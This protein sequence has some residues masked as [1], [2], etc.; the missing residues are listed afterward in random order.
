MKRL[1][2]ELSLRHSWERFIHQGR[3][4]PTVD[5]LVCKSWQRSR[6]FG[7]N[8]LQRKGSTRLSPAEL[9]QRTELRADFI[10]ISL[11][12]MNHLY[13][14]VQGS[15][16]MV[17]L[18]DE[19]GVLLKVFGD[20]ET[21]RSAEQIQFVE[22]ADWSEEV[23]GT[24]AIGTAIALDTPLQIFAAEH[25]SLACH[26]WTCSASPIHSPTGD[27]IGVLNM[28][29]PFEKVHAH[30]LGMVV[31]AVK[32][33]EN[34]LCVLERNVKNEVM[35]RYLEATV[36]ALTESVAIV[37][38]SGRVMKVN[39]L[40]LKLLYLAENQVVGADLDCLVVDNAEAGLLQRKRPFTHRE[41][42]LKV[43][44]N[45]KTIHVLANVQPIFNEN[46]DKMGFL[47]SLKEMRKVRQLVNQITDSQAKVSFSDIIG[48]SSIFME[49]IRESKLAA[50]SDA[51]VL[52]MGESGTGKDLFAQAIHRES[53]RRNRPF[54]AINCGAIPRDLLGSELFGYADGAFTGARKGGSA[55]KFELAD[56][57]TLFLD[58]IGEMSLEMQVLLLR[59]LQSKEI[60]RIGG[61]EVI[62][63]DVRIIAATNK[64]LHKEVRNGHFR[65]D[66]FYRLNVMPI[67]L[68][69]L[70][71]HRED[72]PR[73]ID[74]FVK[75][76]SLRFDRK[77]TNVSPAVV[78]ALVHAQWPGNV[79]ELQNVLERAV[80]KTTGPELV[81]ES[82]PQGFRST[83]SL[84]WGEGVVR[85][86]RLP[87]KEELKRQALVQSIQQSRGNF[88]EAAKSL[89]ISRST[90]YRQMEKFG[91]R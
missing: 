48:E 23:M 41:L 1:K 79:R 22:G 46:G 13:E 71:E 36:N 65:E 72:I 74:H 30:T 44:P 29:G 59:V 49:C 88:K 39:R 18:C 83:L 84:P 52:L 2:D 91:L 63:V 40:F 75:Q 55:G 53:D 69:S 38:A 11:P 17:T 80:L 16:F 86:A 64:D 25:F 85:D 62:P 24:N 87:M 31:S 43:I 5:P 70:R 19:S 21:L 90:L 32:A 28:S 81:M 73:L 14:F 77:I 27:M 20:D 78:Q 82:L 68:P 45:G 89:G 76:F 15:G 35:Q 6:D 57:G 58:E 7:V 9:H 37:G 26:P 12:L 34:Q 67:H 66:L 61:H 33:I 8:P 54:I 4:D 10:S 47:I 3:L 51:T 56:S 42:T 60:V 50:Y